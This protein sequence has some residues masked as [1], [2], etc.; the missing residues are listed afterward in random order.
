MKFYEALGKLI[1]DPIIEGTSSLF[2]INES[3]NGLENGKE[4]KVQVRHQ[5]EDATYYMRPFLEMTISDSIHVD[6]LPWIPSFL[7]M[8]SDKWIVKKYDTD[9]KKEIMIEE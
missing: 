7:D 8:F 1:E 5:Q 9:T 3:W 4:M 6:C 2:M